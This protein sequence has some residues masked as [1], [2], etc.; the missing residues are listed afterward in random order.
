MLPITTIF[1]TIFTTITTIFTTLS[2]FSPIFTTIFTTIHH[3]YRNFYQHLYPAP[4][5][6]HADLFANNK[7]IHKRTPHLS[8]LFFHRS[9]YYIF[10]RSII[11]TERRNTKYNYYNK[12]CRGRTKERNIS[13][14]LSEN[15]IKQQ[16]SS[17]GDDCQTASVAPKAEKFACFGPEECFGW[18]VEEK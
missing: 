13:R 17:G 4:Q 2:P 7:R 8:V 10:L 11:S 5:T 18:T 6:Y 12:N 1:T 16:A 15:V 9:R 3:Y 14:H